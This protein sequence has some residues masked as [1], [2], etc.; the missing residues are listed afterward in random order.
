MLEFTTDHE[1]VVSNNVT[2]VRAIEVRVTDLGF[3]ILSR[4]GAT[5]LSPGVSRGAAGAR[6][7]TQRP[8]EDGLQWGKGFAL[9]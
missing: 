6:A 9:T 8:R 7:S 3:P 1:Q 4:Y 5:P 2:E